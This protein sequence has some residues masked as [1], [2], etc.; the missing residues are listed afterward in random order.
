MRALLAEIPA[1]TAVS[2]L[3]LRID[4][5]RLPACTDA[6]IEPGELVW[7][8]SHL[9]EVVAEER[10]R[11]TCV[12]T[13]TFRLLDDRVGWDPRP[14]DGLTGVEI[15]GGALMLDEHVGLPPDRV[16][17]PPAGVDVRH[18]HVVARHGDGAAAARSVRRVFTSWLETP[19]P[20]IAVAAAAA[21]CSPRVVQ[22]EGVRVFDT[23]TQ[24]QIGEFLVP[25]A[26]AV[27]SVGHAARRRRGRASLG[28]RARRPA[29]AFPIRHR[30]PIAQLAHP[31]PAVPHDRHPPR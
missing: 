8:G 16:M 11:M 28:A 12:A 19:A 31:S 15:A 30:P 17:P 9:L 26:T 13:T 1:L 4:G 24:R 25:E 14:G 22:G 6:V 23:P 20:V 7:P 27:S 29:A 21:C 18:V 2:R 5:R 3:S 10:G